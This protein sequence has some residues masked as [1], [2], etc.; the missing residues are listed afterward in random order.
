MWWFLSNLCTTLC[1]LT[2]PFSSSQ[3]T[4]FFSAGHY[5]FVVYDMWPQSIAILQDNIGS[6]CTV[7]TPATLQW[8]ALAYAIYMSNKINT[9]L[10][11][12][13]YWMYKSVWCPIHVGFWELPP[14]FHS[15]CMSILKHNCVIPYSCPMLYLPLLHYH[16]HITGK[17]IPILPSCHL[18]TIIVTY[19]FL[20]LTR[21]E[22]RTMPYPQ[23]KIPDIQDWKHKTFNNFFFLTIFHILANNQTL[24]WPELSGHCAHVHVSGHMRANART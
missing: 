20:P 1:L 5:K 2:V 6:V 23:Y 11:H 8:C 13:W 16:I 9:S 22:C 15:S 14:Y 18:G 3:T 10:K 24:L 4:G 19:N 7:I 21:K 12:F 17:H